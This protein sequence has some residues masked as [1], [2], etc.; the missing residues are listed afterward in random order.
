[1]IPKSGVLKCLLALNTTNQQESGIINHHWAWN[2]YLILTNNK[3]KNRK[4]KTYSLNWIVSYHIPALA[5]FP[6]NK[7]SSCIGTD[8]LSGLINSRS[9]SFVLFLFESSLSISNDPDDDGVGGDGSI[10]LDGSL[11]RMLFDCRWS[12]KNKIIKIKQNFNY[13]LFK[14]LRLPIFSTI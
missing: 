14:L 5:P 10:P 2:N 13:K 1:M 12:S 6:C 9:G 7:S 3:K 4:K 11:S 8:T